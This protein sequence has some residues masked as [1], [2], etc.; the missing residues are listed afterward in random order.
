MV[1]RF[2]VD[3]PV[4]MS[5]YGAYAPKP[6]YGEYGDRE[7]VVRISPQG[8]IRRAAKPKGDRFINPKGTD[9]FGEPNKSVPFGG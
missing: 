7:T 9:L 5:A 2:A 3:G 8:V 4:T 1:K 6:T